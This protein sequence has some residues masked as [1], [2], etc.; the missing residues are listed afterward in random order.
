MQRQLTWEQ[1]QRGY[2][3]MVQEAIQQ[4]QDMRRQIAENARLIEQL[5]EQQKSFEL[6]P[7]HLMEDLARQEISCVL[8]KLFF[9]AF[10][11]FIVAIV[12]K[13]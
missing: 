4:R 8:V 6:E 2:D 11:L 3:Q 9:F 10:V 7:A 1:V 13:P 5:S 12:F